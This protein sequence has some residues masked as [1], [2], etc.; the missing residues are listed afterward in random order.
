MGNDC[1]MF[2][3][4]AVSDAVLSITQG[5]KDS[6]GQVIDQEMTS[7]DLE[8]H[9][10][11][12]ALFEKISRDMVR[13]GY[14]IIQPM[15]R[16]NPMMVVAAPKAKHGC[17]CGG[18]SRKN[19]GGCGCGAYPAQNPTADT[20]Y[21]Y[22]DMYDYS[23]ADATPYR[24]N[25]AL[26]LLRNPFG[27]IS[28]M[29]MEEGDEDAYFRNPARGVYATHEV[30]G[31]KVDVTK[32]FYRIQVR[33]T[34]LFDPKS[35]RMPRWS[36]HAAEKIT[37]IEGAKCT[38]GKLADTGA[39]AMQAVQVPRGKHSENEE[40]D[41][42]NAVN[43]A[44]R[45][46]NRL[47]KGEKSTGV[48]EEPKSKEEQRQALLA[49]LAALDAMRNPQTNEVYSEFM[50][51]PPKKRASDYD[52]MMSK[53][54]YEYMIENE[55]PF[56]ARPDQVPSQ[57]DGV[58]LYPMP[59]DGSADHESC[60]FNPNA[61][62]DWMMIF[63]GR[64]SPSG[65]FFGYISTEEYN[66]RAKDYMRVDYR[67]NPIVF[68]YQDPDSFEEGY[69]FQTMKKAVEFANRERGIANVAGEDMEY[70]L[71]YSNEQAFS[72]AGFDLENFEV[73]DADK[74]AA[75]V[76]KHSP[77]G[78]SKS[79]HAFFETQ[80]DLPNDYFDHLWD[81]DGNYIRSNPMDDYPEPPEYDD[82]LESWMEER[83][84]RNPMEA[85]ELR[86]FKDDGITI[87]GG[88]SLGR[89]KYVV[90]FSHPSGMWVTYETE[91]N[92][93]RTAANQLKKRLTSGRNYSSDWR[94]MQ[95]YLGQ[96]RPSMH[97]AIE[98]M[99]TSSHNQGASY[100]DFDPNHPIITQGRRVS[101]WNSNDIENFW[102]EYFKEAKTVN[103]QPIYD[104]K[105]R[106]IR[107]PSLMATESIRLEYH[108]DNKNS[109]KYWEATIEG[110]N[111]VVCW[112]RID[113]FGRAGSQTCKTQMFSTE[114]AARQFMLSKAHEKK[115]KGYREQ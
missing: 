75:W 89:G 113:G 73:V 85:D 23:D 36:T 96:Q 51:E 90:T 108:D 106:L 2:W 43:M 81:E 5:S 44:N 83:Y 3:N 95:T 58:D 17:G 53:D 32:N 102:K 4:G 114:Y 9:E 111:C 100:P 40:V 57:M 55:L 25:P 80:P 76:N 30:L 11:A 92:N 110:S 19:G 49:Q 21:D 15:F 22:D 6:K 31:R 91:A 54:T 86:I 82:P 79:I 10:A 12:C 62:A 47:E 104:G 101:R 78:G 88:G 107:N 56:L 7:Y 94:Q 8:S 64:E 14:Q 68:R 67:R 60:I 27:A 42:L 18:K 46:I 115:R 61:K 66:K 103:V 52:E 33:P 13:D 84:E 74:F 29:K 109:H 65:Q 71:G 24:R 38:M 28:I 93:G 77:F 105:S 112:G 20:M 63:A 99:Q 1:T 41:M 45:V 50:N 26:G 34:D 39:W 87:K 16:M 59:P 48:K 98:K 97:A 70:D 69:E 72:E 37:K 35:Y